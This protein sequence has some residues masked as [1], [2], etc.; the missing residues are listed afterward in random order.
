MFKSN[1]KMLKPNPNLRR[2]H[3]L[4]NFELAFQNIVTDQLSEI[5]TLLFNMSY[6]NEDI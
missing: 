5:M 4:V 1:Q 3:L 2:L 6:V